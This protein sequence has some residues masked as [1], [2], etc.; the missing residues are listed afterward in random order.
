[1]IGGPVRSKRDLAAV[2]KQVAAARI[3][4]LV[5]VRDGRVLA[6]QLPPAGGPQE[7]A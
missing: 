7:A 6:A 4:R 1:V 5:L 2:L 3:V